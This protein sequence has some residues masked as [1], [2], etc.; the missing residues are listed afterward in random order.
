MYQTIL[1]AT[2][3]TEHGFKVVTKAMEVVKQNQ[4]TFHII[5]ALDALPAYSWAYADFKAFEVA[6]EQEVRK[7]FQQL[8]EKRSIDGAS[9]TLSRK[10]SKIAIIDFAKESACDLII[11][12]SHSKIGFLGTL[13]STASGV[14]N[15]APCDVLVIRHQNIH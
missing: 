8:A 7:A 9:V 11:L 4:S 1:I 6:Q 15:H 2:D 14:V 12:G 3:L 5:H 13:G 10:P